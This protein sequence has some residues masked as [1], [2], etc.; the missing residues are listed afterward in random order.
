M[1]CCD[2][3]LSEDDMPSLIAFEDEDI[4]LE[5]DVNLLEG[6]PSVI[7]GICICCPCSRAGSTT[8]GGQKIHE[9]IAI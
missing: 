3:W 9:E 6:S 7:E 5:G 4:V 1:I 2:T 8:L